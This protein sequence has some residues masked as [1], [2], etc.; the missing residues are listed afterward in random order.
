MWD[1]RSLGYGLRI[2]DHNLLIDRTEVICGLSPKSTKVQ[3]FL[4]WAHDYQHVG[5]E[6]LLSIFTRTAYP[7]Q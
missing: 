1:D 2:P 3:V 6:A 7:N 5:L 4:S